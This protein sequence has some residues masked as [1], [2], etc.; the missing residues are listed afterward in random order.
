MPLS[1]GS[2]AQPGRKA[3]SPARATGAVH[4]YPHRSASSHGHR[5]HER[6]PLD[7]MTPLRE[8]NSISLSATLFSSNFKRFFSTR[9]DTTAAD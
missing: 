5:R 9:R 7:K 2:R 6:V 3:G 8:P 4:A 1:L